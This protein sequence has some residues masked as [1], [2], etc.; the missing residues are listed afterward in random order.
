MSNTFCV[1][2]YNSVGCTFIDWS[3]YFLSGQLQ[4][5][6]VKSNQWLPVSQNPLTHLY[7]HGH[8]KN[9]PNGLALTKKFLEQIESQPSDLL[10]SIYPVILL[11]ESAIE[12]LNL[13]PESLSDAQVF[14]DLMKFRKHDYN[15]ILKLCNQKQI[16]TVFVADD[17]GTILYFAQERTVPKLSIDRDTE[18]ALMT[19]KRDDFQNMFFNQSQKNWKELGLDNVWDL[20]EQMALNIRPFDPGRIDFVPDHDLSYLWINSVDL[21]TRTPWVIKKI[22]KY[23]QL[24]FS[25]EKWDQ[26]LPVCMSWQK[27]QLDA[28]EFCYNQ[29]HIVNA[30]VNNWNY[31]IDLTFEQEIIIQ[32][33]LIYQHGLN[34]KTWQLERFPNNTQDLHNLLEP[35]IH[36]IAY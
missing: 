4:H 33:C 22:M 2:S 32:H 1:T 15:E 35:N 13:S 10:H 9:H 11:V 7:A 26:W 21:W 17:P 12:Q 24:P 8:A 20:R 30:I 23:L 29:P 31:E 3:V 18:S 27:I 25:S 16:K 28:L 19:Q 14:A 36:P 5:Y 34:L 6:N